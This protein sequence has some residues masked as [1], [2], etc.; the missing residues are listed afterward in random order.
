ML[1]QFG[2]HRSGSPFAAHANASG[3]LPVYLQIS[4]MLIRE[5][6]TGRLRDGER[7][8][9]EREMAASLRRSRWDAAQGAG[10]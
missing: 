8:P 1:Y 7:L 5:I 3:A 4:E 6:G 2:P 9:P 10:S